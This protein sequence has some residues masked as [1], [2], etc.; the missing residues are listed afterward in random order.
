MLAFAAATHTPVGALFLPEPPVER[1]P[2]ADL[3][4]FADQ[5][6]ARPTPDLLE[7][8]FLCQQ[9]QDWYRDFALTVRLPESGFVGSAALSDRPEDVAARMAE[10]LGFDVA[11]RAAC[12]TWVWVRMAH[13]FD[14]AF[15]GWSHSYVQ[16][17]SS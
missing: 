4:T 7:T 5:G 12:R 14:I 11:A 8:I 9:R 3:R 1:L 16:S 2:I 6:L 15:S 10:T 17:F 13:T